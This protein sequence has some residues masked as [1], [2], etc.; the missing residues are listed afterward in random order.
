MEKVKKCGKCQEKKTT[1]ITAK[2]M[3][4][5]EA[6]KFIEKTNSKMTKW[7]IRKPTVITPS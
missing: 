7:L 4:K 6:M 3:E 2:I 1:V 5:K